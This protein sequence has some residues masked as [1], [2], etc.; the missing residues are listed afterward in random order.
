MEEDELELEL[1]LALNN[2]QPQDTSELLWPELPEGGFWCF[3]LVQHA[4]FILLHSA[5]SDS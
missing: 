5:A 4:C 1:Q 2:L 3:G